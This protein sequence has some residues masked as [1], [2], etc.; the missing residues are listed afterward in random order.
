M[1]QVL[2][3]GGLTNNILAPSYIEKKHAERVLSLTVGPP[4]LLRLTLEYISKNRHLFSRS[5]TQR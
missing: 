3:V 2:I 1:L 5:V 4:S